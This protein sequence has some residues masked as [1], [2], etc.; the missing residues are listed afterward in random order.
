M[1]V[2]SSI[3]GTEKTTEALSGVGLSVDVV[4]RRPGQL[5]PVMTARAAMMRERGLLGPDDIEEIVVVR[6]RLTDRPAGPAA[7]TALKAAGVGGDGA[8]D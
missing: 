4:I 8:I 2:H 7:G 3:C 1:V 5:G 6:G